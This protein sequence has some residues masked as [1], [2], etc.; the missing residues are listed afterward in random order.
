MMGTAS[1]AAAEEKLVVWWNKGHYKAEEDALLDV[2]KKFEAKTGVKVELSQ[3][4][5][6][7][8]MP[9]LVAALDAGSPPDV[10]YADTYHFQGAGKWASEGKL[11]DTPSR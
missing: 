11:V 7:D 5:T 2:I 10:T 8:M 3:Y 9:K 4:A 6:Q 1:P